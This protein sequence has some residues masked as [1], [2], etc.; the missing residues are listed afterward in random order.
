MICLFI[1][2]TDIKQLLSCTGGHAEFLRAAPLVSVIKDTFNYKLL[3]RRNNCLLFLGIWH[4]S[5]GI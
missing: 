2:D 1:V 5:K 4:L 3:Q